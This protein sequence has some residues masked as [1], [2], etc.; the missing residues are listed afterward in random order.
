M[1][2]FRLD[3]Q[4]EICYNKDGNRDDGHHLI[5]S[6]MGLTRLKV[7]ISIYTHSEPIL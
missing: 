3:R 5:C 4:R 7:R 6:N 1:F 2:L